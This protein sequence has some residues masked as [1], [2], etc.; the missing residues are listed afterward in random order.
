MAIS[1]APLALK[2]Q[3][4]MSF[5]FI[6]AIIMDF[7]RDVGNKKI[8]MKFILMVFIFFLTQSFVYAKDC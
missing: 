7:K 6:V 8:V 5:P 1:M 2:K 4:L 3:L